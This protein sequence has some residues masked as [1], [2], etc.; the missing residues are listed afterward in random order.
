ME[1]LAKLGIEWKLL[2]AQGVNFA[3]LFFVLKRYAYKPMLDFLATRTERIEQGIKDAEQAKQSLVAIAE[4]EKT[5]LK[6]AREEAKKLIM[7]AEQEAKDRASKRE[8]EA[9]AK[10]KQLLTENDKKLA[11]DREKMFRDVRTEVVDLVTSSVEKVLLEKVDNTKDR[12]LIERFVV[13]G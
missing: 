9:E 6:Q 11:E 2:L 8:L 4:E 12:E 5:I 3:I 7:D 1:I 13:K 10:I